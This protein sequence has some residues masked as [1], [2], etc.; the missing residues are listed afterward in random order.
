MIHDPLIAL[1]VILAG[2]SVALLAIGMVHTR[3]LANSWRG[4]NDR[5]SALGAILSAFFVASAA[6]LV[7]MA[8]IVGSP[9]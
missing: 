4:W 7:F 2:V 3:R 8:A 1:R 6:I 5:L 9:R